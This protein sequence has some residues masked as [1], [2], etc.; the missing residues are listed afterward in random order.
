MRKKIK[1]LLLAGLIQ[2]AFASEV[3]VQDPQSVVRL[4]SKDN[5][6]TISR[7]VGIGAAGFGFLACIP[8]MC[9]NGSNNL[10]LGRDLL[11]YPIVTAS[12]L[13]GGVG[14]YAARN[15][16]YHAGI[17]IKSNATLLMAKDNWHNWATGFGLGF[18]SATFVGSMFL[19]KSAV[20]PVAACVGALCLAKG[21]H[22][23]STMA[24]KDHTIGDLRR[25]NGV[26]QGE[27]K[28]L[29]PQVIEQSTIIANLNFLRGRL[30]EG[31][32]LLES[33]KK[34]LEE[35]LEK[36]QSDFKKEQSKV[37][38]NAQLISS[39]KAKIEEKE[40][41][42]KIQRKDIEDGKRL[43]QVNT[44]ALI[45][46]KDE[47]SY[48]EEKIAGTGKIQLAGLKHQ[49]ETAIVASK[50]QEALL[51]KSDTDKAQH[52]KRSLI[53]HRKKSERILY[54]LDNYGEQFSNELP[55]TEC[56]I[57]GRKRA[58]S[59]SSDFKF[60][61][62]SEKTDSTITSRTDSSDDSSAVSGSASPVMS[63]SN[64]LKVPMMNRSQEYSDNGVSAESGVGL[65]SA[66]GVSQKPSH[67]FYSYSKK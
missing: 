22:G 42:L 19:P 44:E 18:T 64:Y 21:M 23:A 48:L 56:K 20:T 37:F 16:I 57:V 31:A 12:I 8:Q 63:E 30:Q 61:M 41:Q 59:I 3:P 24:A 60:P 46:L 10:P 58:K 1:I 14:L 40:Q 29:K 13:G 7:C 45:G 27:L 11:S 55:S 52:A 25:E 32:D 47:Q 6:T 17:T 65:A 39:L 35:N 28:V 54:S 43:L 38:Q 36:V 9:I 34:E 15:E 26:L 5:L 51:E 50:S 49:L 33:A 4:E 2:D 53:L 66:L 67:V 62:I